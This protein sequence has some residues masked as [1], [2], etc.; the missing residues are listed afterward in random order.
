VGRCSA[1]I[2]AAP[3]LAETQSSCNYCCCCHCGWVCWWCRWHRCCRRHRHRCCCLCQLTH[4]QECVLLCN[5]N[6]L[7]KGADSMH[8][9]HRGRTSM[10]A[11]RMKLLHL[12]S[13]LV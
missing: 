12:T 4:G 11:R 3:Q 5:K 10:Y 1:V 6:R 8:M 7:K 2:A 9:Q 13:V